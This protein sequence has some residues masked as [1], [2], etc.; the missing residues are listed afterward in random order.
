MHSDVTKH[1]AF[2]K[3]GYSMQHTQNGKQRSLFQVAAAS[4]LEHAAEVVALDRELF[5]GCLYSLLRLR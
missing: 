1:S 3:I 4:L 5:D 2:C